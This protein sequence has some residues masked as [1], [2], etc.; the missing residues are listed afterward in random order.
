MGGA[1][2]EPPRRSRLRQAIDSILRR[3]TLHF[4]TTNLAS[5][6]LLYSVKYLIVRRLKGA[7]DVAASSVSNDQ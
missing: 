7:P 4:L 6:I 5:Q 3:D 1:V 2:R